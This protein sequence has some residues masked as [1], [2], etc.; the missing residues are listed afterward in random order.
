M[1]GNNEQKNGQKYLRESKVKS[2]RVVTVA[3]P[4]NVNL[5]G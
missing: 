4:K 1:F 5:F 2:G 3:V